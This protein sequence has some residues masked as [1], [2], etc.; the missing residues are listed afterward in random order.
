MKLT[1]LHAFYWVAKLASFRAAAERIHLAQPTISLRIRELER[2]LVA[3]V[4]ERDGQRVALTAAGRDLLPYAERI[5]SLADEADLR[6]RNHS[7]L[8]GQLRLGVVD[9]FA[10][11][12]LAEMLKLLT[13]RHPKLRTDLTVLHSIPLMQKLR[14]QQLDLAIVVEPPPAPDIAVKPLADLTVRWVAASGA[15]LPKRVLRAGDLAMQ[16][17]LIPTAD[18]IYFSAFWFDREGVY[19]QRVSTC[20]GLSTIIALT[21]AGLGISLLPLYVIRRELRSKT[22]RALRTSPRPGNVKLTAVYLKKNESLDF[23][24][25]VEAARSILARQH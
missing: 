18:S 3:R 14:D 21:K 10:M 9:S 23:E 22:L 25:V 5:L 13:K 16:P 6:L 19:P 15:A 4:F 24:G 1:Q 12:C 2:Q 8:D 17:I 20:S 11:S 7:L